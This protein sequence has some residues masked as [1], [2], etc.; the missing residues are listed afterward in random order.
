MVAARNVEASEVPTMFS[1]NCEC[2]AGNRRT[3]SFRGLVQGV[4]AKTLE[5]PLPEG[6]RGSRPPRSMCFDLGNTDT[7]SDR[8]GS[9][10]ES[11]RARN[12]R[13][14][15]LTVNYNDLSQDSLTLVNIEVGLLNRLSAWGIFEY[16]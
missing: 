6:P 15:A 1:C 10:Q 7:H 9:L 4:V 3:R 5:T 11:R 12:K 16:Q 8:G 2:L 13:T 14:N